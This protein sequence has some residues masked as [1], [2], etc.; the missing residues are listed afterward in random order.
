VDGREVEQVLANWITQA[1]AAPGELAPGTE[2]AQWI[3]RQFLRWWQPQVAGELAAAEVAVAGVRAN[4][5]G[6]G[7][8]SNPELGEALHE[9]IHA[10]EALA[11]LRS[12]LGLGAEDR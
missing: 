10:G 4:L 8:W 1:T 3:A 11:A 5:D 9:L 6:L 7:G 2:P 12:A